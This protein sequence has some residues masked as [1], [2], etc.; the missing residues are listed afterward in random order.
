MMTEAAGAGPP[1]LPPPEPRPDE[2]CRTGCDPCIYDLYFDELERYE[3]ALQAWQG[4]SA[5]AS[6][7]D[8]HA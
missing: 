1:P 6:G 4:R 8:G 3:R 5:T 7:G 2:C